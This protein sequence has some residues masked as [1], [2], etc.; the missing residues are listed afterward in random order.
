MEKKTDWMKLVWILVGLIIGVLVV[1]F[2][3][4]LIAIDVAIIVGLPILAAYAY[5]H[6]L[7]M[8]EKL[9]SLVDKI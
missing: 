9:K 5:D 2:N 6:K 7:E 8:K 1:V 4:V 3:V